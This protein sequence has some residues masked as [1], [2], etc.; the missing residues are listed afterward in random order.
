MSEHAQAVQAVIF[1]FNGTLFFDNDKHVKAWSAISQELRGVP[2]SEDEV[3]N[4]LNGV[5]N[6][7][8]I[9]Y[10]LGGEATSEQVTEYS[11]RK[12]AYYRAFCAEDTEHF[13]LVK[14][15]TRLFEEL[16]ERGVPFTIA[17][18]SIKPNI[19]FFVES[20]GLDRWMDPGSIVYD[21]GTYADKIEMF[22]RA[23][24][25]LG[26]ETADTLVFEDSPNGLA[27][28]RE[29]GCPRIVL[30]GAP[31]D[32]DGAGAAG[33]ADDEVAQRIEDFDGFDR[34]LLRAS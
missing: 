33:A 19:D 22:K 15:A 11:E 4:R 29:A 34:S 25:L 20:F 13:H 18:A 27:N 8:I 1:D 26:A 16:A 28:A 10:L 7:E 21:D 5:P 23:A 31:G 30:V 2:V 14:G 12:E 3:I 24:E 32:G 9:A 17:S 6:K